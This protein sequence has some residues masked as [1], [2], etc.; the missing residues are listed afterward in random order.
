ND[1]GRNKWSV[2]W[3]AVALRITHGMGFHFSRIERSEI[4]GFA[5]MGNTTQDNPKPESKGRGFASMDPQR[6]REIAS[7]GGKSAHA[8]GTAH[9]FSCD[10]ARE[11][12]RR[13]G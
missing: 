11:A 10:E 6:Q 3:R 12:G 5:G 2:T 9:E 7:K 1:S 8:K 4:G 13:G